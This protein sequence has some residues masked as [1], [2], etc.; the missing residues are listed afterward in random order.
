MITVVGDDIKQFLNSILAHV[1]KRQNVGWNK[2]TTITSSDVG[3]I[4]LEIGSTS[5][6]PPCTR[7]LCQL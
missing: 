5:E 1:C 2:T 4:S 3:F 6:S 7:T